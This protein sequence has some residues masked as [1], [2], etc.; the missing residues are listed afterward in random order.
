MSFTD[1]TRMSV[2]PRMIEHGWDVYDAA[3]EKVGD[4]A[5]VREGYL[6]VSKG[7]LFPHEHYVPFS[8]I[9]GVE[10]DR[11]SLS[12]TKDAIEDQGWDEAPTAGAMG[13]AR[14]A[15]MT[16]RGR[17]AE[18]ERTVR[19]REEELRANKTMH[20]TGEVELRKE[21]RTE[22]QTLDVP[23]T[24]EE[25]VI[26]RRPVDRKP[27]DRP[28]GEG[29]SIRVPVREER[30]E[31]EK[32]PVVK[33][34]VSIGKRAV[35]ETERVSGTVRREEARIEREGDAEIEGEPRRRREEPRR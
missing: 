1:R 7:F 24:R 20:E 11:V 17:A 34:E 12:V 19:L 2:D 16:E 30:V 9:T 5:E 23:V 21:V 14:E 33:E 27:D 32:T 28:I 31:V 35:T 26:E 25:V 6:V 13:H 15:G 3:G 4:V 8:A 29:E 18:G 22:R 10:H